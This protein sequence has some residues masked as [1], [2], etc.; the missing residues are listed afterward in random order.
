MGDLG[1]MGHMGDMGG[2]GDQRSRSS[3]EGRSLSKA[4]AI[5]RRP[6]G[7]SQPKVRIQTFCGVDCCDQLASLHCS[8]WQGRL[9]RQLRR[10]KGL[11]QVRWASSLS[12]TR[13]D[14]LFHFL[15]ILVPRWSSL[16]RLLTRAQLPCGG[17]HFTSIRWLGRHNSCMKQIRHT[18][19]LMTKFSTLRRLC[20]RVGLSESIRYSG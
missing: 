5:L 10:E 9:W 4:N 17:G 1:S 12:D 16:F 11:E 2:K 6:P 7:P 13:C 8:R 14:E 15:L 19:H 18:I 3:W 20:W